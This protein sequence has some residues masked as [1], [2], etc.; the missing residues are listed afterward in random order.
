MVYIFNEDGKHALVTVQYACFYQES[1]R[2]FA[3]K[4]FTENDPIFES[5]FLSLILKPVG[6]RQSERVRSYL[7][8]RTSN[9]YVQGWNN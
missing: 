4:C 7:L 5:T 2:T 3:Y 6:I 1:G 8:L 9:S